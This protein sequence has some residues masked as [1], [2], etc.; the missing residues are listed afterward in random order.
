MVIFKKDNSMD[1]FTKTTNDGKPLDDYFIFDCHGHFGP[2]H[3]FYIPGGDDAGAIVA[4]L[5]R[6]GINKVAISSFSNGLP[7]GNDIV[8]GAVKSYPD[9]FVGYAR[10]N[11]NYADILDDELNRC[12]D[13]HGF[14]GIKIH[15]YCDQVAGDDARYNPVWEFSS[16]H[17]APVLI[18]TWNSMRYYDPICDYCLP[19][20]FNKVAEN[21]PDAIIIL[22][23]TGGEYDGVFEAIEVAKK[24]P[25]VYLD[26]ASSR[27]YPDV[28]EMMVREVGAERILYGSDVP[29]ISP[30]PQV[31]KI[32]YA[33]ISESDKEKILG[34]NTAK[35]FGIDVKN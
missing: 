6:I 11:A 15:P 31:G 26:T 2:D 22:G 19:S 10:V 3:G 23:H 13:E 30:V 1:Y 28:I 34:L 4:G 35:L 12:F 16:K 7:F 27:L 17:K 29:F 24:H 8:A 33:D 5:D 25:N 18:H 32:V 14:K 9:R 20:L 21:Y